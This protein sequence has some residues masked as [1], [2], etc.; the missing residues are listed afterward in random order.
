MNQAYW[1][2]VPH[3]RRLLF[4]PKKDHQSIVQVVETPGIKRP[5]CIESIYNV[6]LNY[7][8]SRLVEDSTESVWAWRPIRWQ[9]LHCCPNFFLRK[10]SIDA[11]QV[12]RRQQVIQMKRVLMV[13]R[14]PEYPFIVIVNHF[15]FVHLCRH[16]CPFMMYCGDVAFPISMACLK[17]KKFRVCVS[18]FQVPNARTMSSNSTGQGRK[19]KAAT[20]EVS[21]PGQLIVSQHSG[22]LRLVQLSNDLSGH[23]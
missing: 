9:L 21:T 18:L 22:L 19:T 16:P 2:V 13:K 20:F 6:L 4:F 17:V 7:S 11:I 14:G 23:V 1:S 10:A 3:R 12:N 8:P 5:Q 15:L